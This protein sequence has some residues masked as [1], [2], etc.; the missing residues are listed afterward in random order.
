MFIYSGL[1]E[2]DCKSHTLRVSLKTPVVFRS[3][4][5]RDLQQ[6]NVKAVFARLQALE[7]TDRTPLF[8]GFYEV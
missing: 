7:K 4:N 1:G 6:L 8:K 5:H 2:W 3:A